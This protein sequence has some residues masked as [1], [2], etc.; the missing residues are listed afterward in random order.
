MNYP[1]SVRILSKKEYLLFFQKSEVFRLDACTVFRKSND[2]NQARLGITIKSRVNSVYRNK[3]KRQIKEV[4]RLHLKSIPLFDY[5]VVVPS[6]I[7][8]NYKT[9]KK[10]RASLERIWA[11]ENTY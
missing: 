11:H 9:P 2:L 1:K 10:V 3:L 4:F 6:H 5:N 8:T 7:K